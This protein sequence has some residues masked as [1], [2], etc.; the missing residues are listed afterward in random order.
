MKLADAV[1]VNLS[2]LGH[3]ASR[4]LLHKGSAPSTLQDHVLPALAGYDDD[5]PLPLEDDTMN[6]RLVPL[7]SASI[8]KPLQKSQALSGSIAVVDLDLDKQDEIRATRLFPNSLKL[9]GIKHLCDNML[10]S[11][12]GSLQ[13]RLALAC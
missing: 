11:T 8:C 10:S 4:D 12:L 6:A 3:D 1:Q 9:T 2:Q 5:H 7:P 13:E